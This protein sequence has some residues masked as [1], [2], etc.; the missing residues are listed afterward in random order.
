MSRQYPKK[1]IV[2]VGAVILDDDRI[3]ALADAFD[4]LTSGQ[5]QQH[6]LE[7]ELAVKEL[8]ADSGYRFDPE[9]ISAFLQA[10]RRG[11][12]KIAQNNSTLEVRSS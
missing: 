2:G 9:V 3:L 8:A 5:T 6:I 10:W 7:P 1:P 12:L 4:S 11:E